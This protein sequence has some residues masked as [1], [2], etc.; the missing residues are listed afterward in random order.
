MI[1]K[2]RN[3]E[4]FIRKHWCEI[5]RGKVFFVDAYNNSINRKIAPTITT[6]FDACNH[7][8][9][10]DDRRQTEANTD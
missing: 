9:V 3:L 1:R 5:I 2:S 8:F 7:Y 10:N 4:A 6:R